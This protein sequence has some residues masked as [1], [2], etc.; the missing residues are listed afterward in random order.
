MRLLICKKRNTWENNRSTGFDC[1]KILGQLELNSHALCQ[2]KKSSIIE[3]ALGFGVLLFQNTIIMVWK[4]CKAEQ[5]TQTDVTG[6]RSGVRVAGRE[7]RDD[8][9]APRGPG[10]RSH[11]SR[12]EGGS[13]SSGKN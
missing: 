10:R 6:D 7:A 5:R 8:G 9:G 4:T 11:P 12:P 2:A 3:L 1:N 13:K